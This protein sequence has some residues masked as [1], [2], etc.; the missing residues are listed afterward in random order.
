MMATKN[1]PMPPVNQGS[2]PVASTVMGKSAAKKPAPAGYQKG[3][4]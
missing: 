3:G 4:K 1:K 2:L